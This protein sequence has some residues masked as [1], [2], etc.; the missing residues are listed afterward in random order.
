MK[1]NQ[2]DEP[3]I[4][5]EHAHAPRL[6]ARPHQA[7]TERGARE[8]PDEQQRD[9]EYD[10]GEVVEARRIADIDANG[11]GRSGWRMPLSPPV[12]SFAR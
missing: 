4:V 5:P 2:L 6:I 8:P 12:R 3:D 11:I 10:Q 9:R 1:V 7:G